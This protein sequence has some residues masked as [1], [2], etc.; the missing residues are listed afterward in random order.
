[1]TSSDQSNALNMAIHMGDSQLVAEAIR[2]SKIR[3]S[4]A[5]SL[6]RRMYKET[7]NLAAAWRSSC[8]R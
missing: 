2:S 7:G 6:F 3:F 8:H 1:M 4:E 5:E